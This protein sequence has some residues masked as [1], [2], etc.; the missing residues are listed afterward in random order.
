MKKG[1]KILQ[2]E[3]DKDR[4]RHVMHLLEQLWSDS[5]RILQMIRDNFEKQQ[6]KKK[7]AAEKAQRLARHNAQ[8]ESDAKLEKERADKARRAAMLKVLA[9]KKLRDKEI[10]QERYAQKRQDD[11]RLSR[12][13]EVKARRQKSL[14]ARRPVSKKQQSLNHDFSM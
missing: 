3:A 12:A 5:Q 7:K 10:R 8:V 4:D 9:K 1:A 14:S 11:P 2:E 13:Q 6:N